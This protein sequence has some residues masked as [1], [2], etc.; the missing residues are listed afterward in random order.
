MPLGVFPYLQ[1]GSWGAWGPCYV[2]KD[3]PAAM[4]TNRLNVEQ[5]DCGHQ[6]ESQAAGLQ[7]GSDP[8]ALL[9]TLWL[10][11]HNGNSVLAL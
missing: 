6:P 5:S 1:C 3:A 11:G 4:R 10:C 8:E 2:P 7:L 9:G